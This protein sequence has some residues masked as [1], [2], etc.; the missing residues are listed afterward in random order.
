MR[1]VQANS[2]RN[3]MLKQ[4]KFAESDARK[5]KLGPYDGIWHTGYDDATTM[6]ISQM[7]MELGES[8]LRHGIIQK[9]LPTFHRTLQT[10]HDQKKMTQYSRY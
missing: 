8:F 2:E 6:K 1:A 3:N 10:K 5:M 7:M 9:I 4:V